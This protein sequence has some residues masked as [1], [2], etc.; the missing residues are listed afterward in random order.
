MLP[1]I[2]C[3][4]C[5]I[6]EFFSRKQI[7]IIF[8]KRLNGNVKKMETLNII[9]AMNFFYKCYLPHVVFS[10]W[11]HHELEPNKWISHI[12]K[13]VIDLHETNLSMVRHELQDH[14][15]HVPSVANIQQQNKWFYPNCTSI[16]NLCQ[17]AHL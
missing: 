15:N 8:L 3:F 5:K 7:E 2:C 1:K 6:I 16:S 14:N 17:T 10:I 9:N 12:I 11:Y 13:P 4:S